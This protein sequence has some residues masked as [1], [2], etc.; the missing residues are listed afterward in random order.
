MTIHTLDEFEVSKGNLMLLKL[1]PEMM[2][3]PKWRAE[4]RDIVLSYI[5]E[6]Q[7]KQ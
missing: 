2:N 5:L 3:I 7:K 4:I 6:K 1:L